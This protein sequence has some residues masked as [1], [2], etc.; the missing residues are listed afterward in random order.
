MSLGVQY[1]QYLSTKYLH[2]GLEFK[3]K[4]RPTINIEVSDI[5]N[6]VIQSCDEENSTGNQKYTVE[7]ATKRVAATTPI[8]KAIC[9]DKTR[10]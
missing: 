4:T 7:N 5:I 3:T 9:Q 6:E 2:I 10:R 1:K 8:F